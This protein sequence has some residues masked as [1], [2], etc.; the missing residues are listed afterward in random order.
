[1]K[2]KVLL[3]IGKSDLLIPGD[4]SF[5]TEKLIEELTKRE[6]IELVIVGDYKAEHF[7]YE[8]LNKAL[9]D[10]NEE[11]PLTII[12][13]AHGTMKKGYFEFIL[14][15]DSKL[16]SNVLFNLLSQ[17]MNNRAIDIFTPACHG[18]GMI[19]DRDLLPA[20]S[21]LI[22]LTDVNEVNN[23]SDFDKISEHL[24]GFNEDLSSY[25]LLQLFLSKCLKNRFHPHIGISGGNDYSLDD[26]LKSYISKPLYFDSSHFESLG[27]QKEYKEVFD[28]IVSSKSEW[29]IYA[30]EYGL[31]LSI[32]LNDLKNKG[33]FDSSIEMK[34]I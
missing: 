21:T 32:V 18:G 12:L 16:S 29:S 15:L 3:I 4:Y 11:Q 22:A 9:Y 6:D 10:L 2:R 13:D 26:M 23:G 34:K 1:M 8:T 5:K 31:A 25:N 30:A 24:E 17:R 14:D 27:L 20:G 7:D 33:D 19:R 28:K